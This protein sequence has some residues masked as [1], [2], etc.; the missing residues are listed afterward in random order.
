MINWKFFVFVIMFFFNV[1][2]Y[3]EDMIYL[4]LD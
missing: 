4:V 1:C 3:I 2:D